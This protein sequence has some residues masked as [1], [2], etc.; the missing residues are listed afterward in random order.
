MSTKKII[1]V[2]DGLKVI[3]KKFDYVN[4][5]GCGVVA[6]FISEELTK[7]NIKHDIIWI[8]YPNQKVKSVLKKTLKTNSNPSLYDI[9][10]ATLVHAMIRI[11]RDKFVDSTG[12]TKGFNNT[13]WWRYNNLTKVDIEI[14]RTLALNPNGWN[15]SFNRSQIKPIK[16]IV[17]KT[18]KCL[19]D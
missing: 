11:G 7:Y 1:E 19:V 4:C 14:L 13:E 5:G 8:A 3:D 15:S 17:K 16:K 12:V 18:L 6:L 10:G 9:N 2:L